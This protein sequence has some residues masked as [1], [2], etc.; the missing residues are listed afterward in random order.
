MLHR[1]STTAS[2][3]ARFE[4]DAFRNS[5]V[6]CDVRGKLV[7]YSQH[8]RSDPDAPDDIADIEMVEACSSC[9][10][11]VVRKR[12]TPSSYTESI[13]MVTSIWALSDDNT[14][15]VELRME[16]S[17]MY[18]PYSSYFSPAKASITIPCELRFHDV[19]FGNRL[20]RTARTSWVNFVFEDAQG[21][22]LFQNEIMGRTLLATFRTCKTMRIHEGALASFAFAEQMCALENLRIWEDTDTGAVIALIHFSATFR[23]G[24]LAFY[25]N[26]STN[27]VRVQDVGGREVK[28]KGLRV[29]IAETVKAMRKDSV[30]DDGDAITPTNTNTNAGRKDADTAGKSRRQSNFSA[31]KKSKEK[32]P[33]KSAVEA[34]TST[35]RKKIISG[36]KVEFASEHEKSEFLRLVAEYQRPGRLC[37]VPDLLGV[38]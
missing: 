11:A 38:N 25:I 22:A 23:D 26:S 31:R 9:R 15:R 3:K 8:T 33:A 14:V 19:R 7:D 34:P 17:E 29:P 16:D 12:I 6:L 1:S 28:I 27:P 32:E 2:Q 36:A 10:I 18:I 35:D 24:Y 30:V 5:A 20:V 37:E 13:R 21:A 4:K